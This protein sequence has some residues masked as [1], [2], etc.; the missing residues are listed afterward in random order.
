MCIH[1]CAWVHTCHGTGAE[2][3]GQTCGDHFHLFT[4]DQTQVVSGLVANVL[5]Y[6]TSP[7]AYFINVFFLLD[8][9][10]SE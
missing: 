1:V 7:Q 4:K 6:F 10:I 8:T 9:Y 5:I 2:V 3:R